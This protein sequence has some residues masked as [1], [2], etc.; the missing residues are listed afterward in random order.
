MW[1]IR[2]DFCLQ[3]GAV[4]RIRRHLQG[5]PFPHLDAQPGQPFDLGRV[6]RQHP[7][8]PH[9]QLLQDQ[10]GGGVVALVGLMAQQQVGVNRV[11]TVIL[12]IVG[13]QLLLQGRCPALPGADR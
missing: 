13:A 7:H 4:F 9:A 1:R 5:D 11:V 8:R 10:G 12:Q 6:V 2:G 3:I